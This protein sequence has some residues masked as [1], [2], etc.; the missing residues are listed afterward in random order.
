M[1]L[2]PR[3]ACGIAITLFLFWCIGALLSDRWIW[4]QWLAWIPTIFVILS[5]ALAGTV[6]FVEKKKALGFVFFGGTIALLVFF[7]CVEHQLLKS[8]E[9]EGDIKI[10]G[11]TMSHPKGMVAA[12]SAECIVQLNGDITLLTHGWKVRGEQVL[13]DWLGVSGHK[14]INSQFTLLT[15]FAPLQVQ[16]LIASNGIYISSFTLDTSAVLKKNLVLWAVDF[17]STLVQ[18]KMEIAH[19]A[20]R[21]LQTIETSPPDIVLGDFNMTRNSVAIETMFPTLKDAALLSGIGVLASYPMEFPLYHIDHILI[22]DTL[23]PT[24][25]ELFNSH[26]GRHR[27]QV[28]EV[29]NAPRP[30]PKRIGDY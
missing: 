14:V 17:P 20:L 12:E 7:C 26:I 16:T 11:W 3:I 18:P 23:R 28:M 6:C 10:V 22:S 8:I 24:Y 2:F 30:N 21:L 9:Q 13:R 15:K 27:I 5:I 4:S 25:Y 19:R 1:K 29:E